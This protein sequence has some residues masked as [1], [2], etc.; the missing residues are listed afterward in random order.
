MISSQAAKELYKAGQFEIDNETMSILVINMEHIPYLGYIESIHLDRKYEVYLKLDDSLG[1]ESKI[2]KCNLNISEDDI[3]FEYKYEYQEGEYIVE[4]YN[5][6]DGMLRGRTE[7]AD[8]KD[9]GFE[10]G[11]KVIR[12]DN[13]HRNLSLLD[14]IKID[15]VDINN[16]DK[17]KCYFNF[18]YHTTPISY[19]VDYNEL[20][21]MLKKSNIGEEGYFFHNTKPY[22]KKSIQYILIKDKIYSA[23]VN[24]GCVSVEFKKR[25]Y[26]IIPF[27]TT[28][29]EIV[30]RLGF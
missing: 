20:F 30:R 4:A 16:E 19:Y 22:L 7:F 2:F 5:K 14:F 18:E 27:R 12:F 1:S 10:I 29:E 6:H 26:D 11:G 17:V 23:T 24:N 21:E 25:I 13:V 8:V 15:P 9:R 28:C 3:C